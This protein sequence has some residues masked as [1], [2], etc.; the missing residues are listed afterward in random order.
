[1]PYF[2]TAVSKSLLPKALLYKSYVWRIS[3]FERLVNSNTR[4]DLSLFILVM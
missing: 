2:L 4:N 3:L 1:V